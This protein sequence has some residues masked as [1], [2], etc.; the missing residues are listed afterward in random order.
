MTRT[1]AEWK[2]AAAALDFDGRP[3]IG[4]ARRAAAS[5]RTIEKTNPATGEVISQIHDC[6][7]E[8]VDAAVAAARAAYESG[9][10]SR[11][12]AGFRRE[13]L[14]EFARL[15]EARADEFALYDSLDMGKPVRESSTIDAPGSAALYR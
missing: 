11:A 14:L 1:H 2:A 12:G 7:Q 9:S 6:G 13:R 3:V 4:G 10:W 15:I 5:G 8:E